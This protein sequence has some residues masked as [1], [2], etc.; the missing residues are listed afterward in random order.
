MH[1]LAT[2]DTINKS[3]CYL[4]IDHNLLK[5]SRKNIQ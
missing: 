4:F 2:K 3:S 1:K 5:L